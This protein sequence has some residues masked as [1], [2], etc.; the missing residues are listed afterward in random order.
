MWF[1]NPLAKI[2][3]K[4]ASIGNL[5]NFAPLLA[6]LAKDVHYTL[7]LRRVWHRVSILI[8]DAFPVHRIRR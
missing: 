4:I 6:N 3:K 5:T 2:V 8:T 7:Y 1:E